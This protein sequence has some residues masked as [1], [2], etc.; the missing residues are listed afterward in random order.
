MRRIE[1]RVKESGAGIPMDLKGW[2]WYHL[3]GARAG[4]AIRVAGEAIH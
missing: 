3:D 2:R 4:E 1:A